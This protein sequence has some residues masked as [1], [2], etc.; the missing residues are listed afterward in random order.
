MK[1]NEAEFIVDALEASGIEASVYSNYSGR[2]MYGET[3]DGV[4]TGDIAS[5][6]PA[7]VRFMAE[8]EDNFKKAMRLVE[9][10]CF[11]VNGYRLDN[12]ARDY[13]IY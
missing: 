2:G 1:T 10:G 7:I 5:I 6:A 13:I 8:D 9:E 12:M 3:T 4:V 11:P